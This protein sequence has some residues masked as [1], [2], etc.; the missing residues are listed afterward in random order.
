MGYNNCEKKSEAQL[1]RH[2]RAAA[3]NTQSVI[4][5]DH[6]NVQM[7]KRKVSSLEVYECLR[8][9]TIRRQPEPNE[10][11]GSLECRMQR[12]VAGRELAVIVALCDEDPDILVVTVFSVD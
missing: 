3:K 11:K 7:S 10:M 4:F 1:A 8:T 9:G 5:T 2:I 12:Y 6:A